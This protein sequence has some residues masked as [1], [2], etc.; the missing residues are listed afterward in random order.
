M[1]KY[2]LWINGQYCQSQ[3]GQYFEVRNPANG[4]LIAEVARANEADVDQAIKAAEA[5]FKNSDW[6]KNRELRYHTL[7][8]LAALI[9][10]NM[11]ELMALESEITGRPIREM[12]AQLGRLPD[13]YEFFASVTNTL[14]DEAHPF[15]GP[16]VNYTERL[17]LG[18]VA[19]VTPWNHPLMILTKKLAPAL[20]AGN[21]VVIKPSEDAPVTPTLLAALTKQAGVPDGIVNLINGFGYDVGKYLTTRPVFAKIDLTGGTETG[22]HV[23]AAAGQNLSKVAA[24]L[25]G[26]ASLLVLPDADIQE[27]VNGAAFASFIATGQTCIQG[28]R[29][30]VHS[31]KYREFVDALVAKAKGLR[32]GNPRELATD[33]G[34]VISK[35]QYD[36]ILSYIKIGVE[37]G[38]KVAFGGR[39][40]TDGAYAKGYFIEPTIFVDVRNDM[41]ICQEEIFGPVTCVLKYDT[42]EELI[43]T[44]NATEMGLAMAVWSNDIRL[45]HRIASQLEAGIVYINDYHRATPISPWGGF[46]N[47]GIGSENSIQCYKDYTKIRSV[48]VNYNADKFDWFDGSAQ[49]K[50]YT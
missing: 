44:A 45:A 37:E 31:S 41:R 24:E 5:A 16:Y 17:P 22:R 9:R 32:V 20:A 28:S 49:V 14:S 6:A 10:E 27:A 36:R 42:V 40:L 3:G 47:S 35:K 19:L 15:N 34:P 23:A 26:K 13:W 25:G 33:I 21:A 50:R 4:E 8:R 43:A 11:P 48:I 38:A 39:A 18:V 29:I 2:D 30:L 7:N 46:K 1:K 12:K